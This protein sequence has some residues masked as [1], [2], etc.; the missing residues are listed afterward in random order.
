MLCDKETLTGRFKCNFGG[1]TATV[2]ELLL[3]SNVSGPGITI[4]THE[5][6]LQ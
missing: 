3:H 2:G 6:G 5:S 4:I 1:A